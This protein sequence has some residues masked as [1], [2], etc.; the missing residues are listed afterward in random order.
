MRGH[1]AHEV[2]RGNLAL[3]I[4]KLH[5]LFAP[6]EKM[7]KVLTLSNLCKCIVYGMCKEDFGLVPK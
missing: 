4:G 6:W 3:V 5:S 2:L 7:H 1:G